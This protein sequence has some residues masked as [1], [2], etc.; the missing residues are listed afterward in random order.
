MRRATVL[1]GTLVV[2]AGCASAVEST[3][4]SDSW[5]GSSIAQLDQSLPA[6]TAYVVYDVSLPV[7]KKE[8]LY[9]TADGGSNDRWIIVASCGDRTQLAVAVLSADD[10]TERIKSR[11]AKREFDGLLGECAAMTPAP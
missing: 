3:E 11:A 10:Y 9:G 8:P 7:V 5:V 2:L 6:D 1:L 4:P